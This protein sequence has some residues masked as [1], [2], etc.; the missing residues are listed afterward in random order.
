LET[1]YPAGQA[2]PTAIT[3]GLGLVLWLVTFG[4]LHGILIGVRLMG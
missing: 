3:A 2:I 4:W 1:V